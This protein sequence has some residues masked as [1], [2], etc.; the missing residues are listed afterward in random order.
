MK[1]TVE[2]ILKIKPGKS[3]TFI[4]ESYKECLGAKSLAVYVK[5]A[6]CP[7]GVLKYSTSIDDDA[8][9]ITIVAIKEEN[10]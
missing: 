7:S 5:K 6:H 2:D 10:A 1:P 3:K 8:N 9:A 4:C